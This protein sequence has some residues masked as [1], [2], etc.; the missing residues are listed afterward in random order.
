VAVHL[1]TEVVAARDVHDTGGRTVIPVGKLTPDLMGLDVGPGTRA[2]FREALAGARTV[3]WN[4][5]MGVFEVPEFREGTL[6]MA[7]DLAELTKRGATTVVGGGDS[8]SAIAL[9]GRKDAVSFVSTGGG[10]SLEFLEGIELPG[11]RALA[12][13][14]G[15]GG[16]S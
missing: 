15:G 14:P 13:P 8:A 6:A 2:R 1:P 16:P 12:E 11:L 3:F 7:R 9:A 10:A 5:P 4:G